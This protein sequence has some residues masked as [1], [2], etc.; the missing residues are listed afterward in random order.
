MK[1][2]IYILVLFTVIS[3]KKELTQVNPNNVTQVNFWKNEKDVLSGLAATYKVFKT[4]F[5]GYWGYK[6]VQLAN[7]RGDDMYIRNDSKDMYQ[8]TTFT[9]T[10]TTSIP[11][12]M[13][14]GCYT[15]IYRANQVI[16][17]VPNADIS[18]DLKTTYIAEARFLR[19]LNYFTLV[20]NFGAV[21][22]ITTL[23]A[24]RQDYFVKQS[25]EEDVWQQII[26]DLNEAKASLPI[27]YPSQFI[28]R[29]T[30]G[31]AVGYL[32]K[33]YVYQKKWTE[34]E[35]E[36]K[37]LVQP[38][39]Q[40]Q[41]P[42]TYNLLSNFEDNFLK[43][44]DNNVESLFE[45]Q[46]QNV[47][48][49]DLSGTENANETQGTATAQA[50]APTEVGGWFQAYPTNK[51]FDEFQKEKT[52]ANDYDPRM[53]ASIVWD[54]PNAT[55]YNKPYSAFSVLFA[56][57]SRIKKYQN[58]QMNNEEPKVSEI[59]EKALR[60]ADILL[61]Y[62]ET[63]TVMGRIEEAYP[64]INRIRDRAK[65]LPLTAGLK[66]EGMLTEI[67][68]QRMIEFVR[69]GQRF[70]DLKRWNLLSEEIS[71]SDKEGKE[72]FNLQKH[73]YFPIPQ[74]EINTNPNIQQNPAW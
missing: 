32:A 10:P 20:I 56:K 51:M 13:Y 44:K 46:N 53:Y 72:F 26:N 37:L 5:R 54:Y 66:R 8:L 71:N 42:Y 60:F 6:G 41:A 25:A 30:K 57:K 65:L 9:N 49:L 28:G 24:E 27:S 36:F 69:E 45:I 2:I 1:K 22:L 39:G 17:N 68:H 43:E 48:G 34:A 18:D 74:N 16:A 7:G 15:G 61:L 29:A 73:A 50:F 33:A 70:Y 19:A 52:V 47:G 63:L 38:G 64:M 58:W 62:G 23:P 67:R 59:N 55:F 40:A 31:A 3:C 11:S 12:D 35:A 4:P 21:P 14:A